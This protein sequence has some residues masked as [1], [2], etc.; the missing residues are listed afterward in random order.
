MATLTEFQQQ[1]VAHRQGH[2]RVVAVAGAGKTTTLTHF[3]AARLQEGVP[4]RRM[5]VLMYN[6]S[7]KIDF[8]HKLQQLLP[9]QAR[10]EIRTF[11]ALGLRIYQRLIQQQVLSPFH[12]KILSDSEIELIVW[13]LLQQ[14]ADGPMRQ[15]ILSQRK[16]WVEPALAF[17]DLVK[18]GLH[19][20]ETVFKQQQFPENCQIFIPMFEH[21]ERWRKQQQRISYADMLYDPVKALCAD[22]QLAQQFG[23]HMQ[24]ILVDEYQD[25]NA[26]QQALLDLL[27][28]GT[29]HVMVIGDPDQTIYEFRGSRPEFIV[30]EFDRTMGQVSLYQLPHSF[31]YGHQL[32]LLANHLITHNKNRDTILCLSHASA[33]STQVSWLHSDHEAQTIVSLIQQQAQQRPLTDIAVINRIWALCAPIELGLLRAG[34][35]YNLHHSQSVL[36]R[37]ELKIF[38]FLFELAAGQF[39]QRPASERYEAWLH[40]LTTPYP[41]IKHPVL[42]QLAQQ[43][44]SVEQ[45]YAQ[46]LLHN[47]PAELSEWQVSSLQAR[48]EILSDIEHIKMPAHL[49]MTHYIQQTQ[50]LEGLKD[51]SFSEQQAD[52]QAETI[53][54]FVAFMREIQIGADQALTYLQQL[55][56][57]Q[58]EQQTQQGVQLISVHK[59][60]G[61]EWPVVIIPGLNDHYFPYQ[62]S[63]DFSR[64]ANLE[65]ERRLLYVALTRAKEQLYLLLPKPSKQKRAPKE[66]LGTSL[67][68]AELQLP[69]SAAIGAALD[70]QQPGLQLDA[71]IEQQAEWLPRYLASI[72]QTLTLNWKPKSRL[73][74]PVQQ[75]GRLVQRK[76]RQTTTGRVIK[77]QILGLGTLTF[78]DEHYWV[79]QFEN[80]LGPRT[81]NRQA[82]QAFIEDAEKG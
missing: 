58:R 40:F 70:N 49:L 18:S 37:Y 62:P 39:A 4:P 61:L 67:F 20:P 27:H 25:I 64:P 24:W 15:D 33:T 75:L 31:R 2:A 80:E 77:H 53:R 13:R 19:S 69:V 52:D 55:K 3:I 74:N 6:R 14:L 51:N 60:K 82:V 9:Q 63:G 38:W 59:S 8:E 28:A 34:I 29:G 5:L 35:A 36:D 56:K 10:P 42:K 76:H 41:K 1:V 72:E 68:E 11:H 46:A 71:S 66:A 47:L 16:K 48:A 32:A 21:F 81:F 44:A 43:M 54:A 50:L 57:Q 26:I 45:D 23:G 78:E 22:A 65:S 7:A 73:A 12:E 17:I 79:I 30:Q